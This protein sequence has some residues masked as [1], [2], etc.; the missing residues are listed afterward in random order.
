VATIQ[1]IKNYLFYH[2]CSCECELEHSNVWKKPNGDY[3]TFWSDNEYST[4]T[5]LGNVLKQL[6]K[7]VDDFNRFIEAQHGSQG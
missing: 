1:D 7:D 4:V 5:V 6:D 2:K 3:I